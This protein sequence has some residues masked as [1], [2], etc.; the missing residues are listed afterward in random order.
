MNQ[1]QGYIDFE[2]RVAFKELFE[3]FKQKRDGRFTAKQ[4]DSL[5]YRENDD[6]VSSIGS[7]DF[8]NKDYGSS[9][10]GA[11]MIDLDGFSDD[12]LSFYKSYTDDSAMKD[13]SKHVSDWYSSLKSGE[14][15]S[16]STSSLFGSGRDDTA[17]KSP[18][19]AVNVDARLSYTKH[20]ERFHEFMVAVLGM[21]I[22][23]AVEL[24]MLSERSGELNVVAALHRDGDMQ[25]WTMQSKEIRLQK[26][27]D[28]AGQVL[29][30]DYPIWDHDYDKHQAE[31]ASYPE[32]RAPQL[33]GYA[34]RSGLHWRGQVEQ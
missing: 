33:S 24:W 29:V 25:A 22:F 7:S 5:R 16:K 20:R 13:S 19:G 4:L 3:G 9:G 11:F 17:T 31:E 15:L 8:I 32:P 28:V 23:D 21:T 26:G 14:E 12:G 10:A 1:L 18:G 6:D 2:E 27:K 34:L 30:S